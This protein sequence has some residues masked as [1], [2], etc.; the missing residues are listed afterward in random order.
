MSAHPILIDGQWSPSAGSETFQ[1]MNP[2]TGELLPDEYPVSTWEDLEKVLTAADRAQKEMAGWP[3]SR[4]ADFLERYADRVDARAE[5]IVAAAH[6][7]TA[8]PAEG[9]L[10][11]VELPR[12]T[13]QM[14]Q[15][16]EAARAATWS[17][18]VI[19]TK[20]NIR[21]I[22]GAIGPVMVFGPNNF[23]LAI[24]SVSGNDMASAVVAGNPV[25]AKGHPLHPTTTRLLAE[26]AIQA[27]NETNMPAG[28]IQL[29]YHMSAE[30]GIKMI[31]DPRI[32]AV[33]FTG[34]QVAGLKI[35]DVADQHGKPAYLEMSSVNP[36]VMLPGVLKERGEEVATEF[37]GS[38]LL[39]C[40]QF[41]TN[42][43]LLFLLES[44]ETE[45]FVKS[46]TNQFSEAPVGTM[47]GVGVRDHFKAGIKALQD[48]GAELLTG[49]KPAADDAVGFQNTLLRVSGERYLSNSKALQGEAF[50]NSSLFV[51]VKDEA[52]LAACLETI[53]GNLTGGFYSAT[54][55][56]DDAIYDRLEPIMRPR[57]G[58]L[59]NDKMPTGVAVS[60]AMNHGGPY[61][62]TGHA[63]FTAI[64]IPA[65][66]KRFAML[67]CY[68]NV[69]DH[70]LPPELQNGNPN[71]VVRSV[72]GVWSDRTL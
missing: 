50:G 21:S 31:A 54:D 66:I 38:C 23:P 39:G 1:A 19:D 53:E 35:K 15:A 33:G 37:S 8:L 45:A 60:P 9:R 7:E 43:G 69:R 49:G 61:P 26:E 40:G 10:A 71:G 42:P 18:P 13:N 52:E 32:A 5:E 16:A 63:G 20:T 68:D 12:T 41:C 67:R 34:S 14:R 62:S 57:V 72:D 24:N 46:V 4:F 64:G 47:L 2:S 28:F 17:A 6:A 48:A 30:D 70:R 36:L 55:G 58:R 59:L 56:S 51:V 65:S 44:D 25:I 22:Y 29:V 11:K 3:A 27:A